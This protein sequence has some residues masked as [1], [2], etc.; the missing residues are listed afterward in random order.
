LP[1]GPKRLPAFK[2]IR[3][4]A[5]PILGIENIAG[6]PKAPP[7]FTNIKSAGDGKSVKMVP[8]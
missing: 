4:A 1:G 3:S 2:N 5:V 7:G 6:R 8:I